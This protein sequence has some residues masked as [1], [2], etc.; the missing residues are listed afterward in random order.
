VNTP[1]LRI[2]HW[3]A[4]VVG[5]LLVVAAIAI[6]AGIAGLDQLD[7]RRATLLDKIAPAYTEA[8]QLSAA[9]V[10]EESGVRGYVLAKERG[11]LDPYTRGREDEQK[12]IAE[13]ER[14][15]TVSE[16]DEVQA[17]VDEVK[18]RAD[19]WR[20][21]YAE[22]AIA[23]VRAGGDPPSAD[24]GKRRFDELRAALRAQQHDLDT[25]RVAARKALSDAAA[26]VRRLFIGSGALIVVAVLMAAFTLRQVVIRPIGRLA[27]EVRGVA[28]G[29]FETP[30]EPS[31]PVEIHAL[32]TDVD[33]MRG[34][35]AAEVAALR[36]AEK[37]LIEQAREL[38]RSNQE[39]EQFAYVASHDLQEPLRKVAS[40]T[41]MLQRRYAGQLDERADRYIEFA[42]DGAKRMQVLINDL[43]DFSRVG[44]MGRPHEPVDCD[45]LVDEARQRLAARI[46][47]TG[48][49]VIV[50][51]DLPT[52]I[53]DAGLLTAVF[54]NL[55]ANGLKFRGEDPPRVEISAER[56]NGAWQFSV[57]D[58]GIGIDDE[59]AERIFVI[60]QRL[61][62]RDSYEGTGIGLA[63]CRKIVEYHGGRIWLA[64]AESGRGARFL[65]T[66]PATERGA[67]STEHEETPVHE[68]A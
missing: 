13:L 8:L 3:F 51:G 28:A 23:A 50:D 33:T 35:I 6:T 64:P 67:P 58:Y 10:D 44:R 4:L 52:V 30:V 15:A 46:E 12:A 49:A 25:S 54:Q 36:D 17:D 42:V 27:R 16:L 22:P 65:F 29:N 21:D 40:F 55:I 2:T 20:G 61:H 45:E 1:R 18:R 66:L 39:L 41:Q 68:H 14:R 24:L 32:G 38:Q 26:S 5:L 56:R 31:G 63:M 19:A 11:F 60:F 43:L 53:G 62:T 7:E 34:R 47:E 9:L 59:Y 57:T 48:G 37:A